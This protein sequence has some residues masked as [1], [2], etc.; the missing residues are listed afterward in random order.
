LFVELGGNV[1]MLAFFKGSENV[2]EKRT[3]ADDNEKVNYIQE[4]FT[5][6]LDVKHLSFLLGCGCSSH[7]V[8]DGA[9]T[10]EIG[11]PVMSILTSEFYNTLSVGDKDWLK[12]SQGLDIIADTF[13]NNLEL[14][15]ATLLSVDFYY[16]KTSNIGRN[17]TRLKALL[18]RARNF[19]LAKCLNEANAGTADQE[20]TKIYDDFYRKL[21][22]RNSNLP[23]PNIFTTNYDLYSEKALDR[24][25]INYVNGF[26]GGVNKYFNPTIFNYTLAERMD[27]TQNKWSQIDNIV[28]LYKLHGSVNWVED[29]NSSKLFQFREIQ[30][31][32]LKNLQVQEMI[33]IYPTPQKYNAT[34]GSPYSDLFRE[35]QKQL[36]QNN[37]ILVT[38]GYSFSD[39]HINNLIY[40]AFTIPSFRL[41]VIGD[42]ASS[43]SIAKLKELNDPR[44]WI[45]HGECSGLNLHYFKGFVDKILPDLSNEEIEDK[46]ENAIRTLLT[47]R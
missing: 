11:I 47:K 30:D 6:V 28:Y 19:L 36:M 18:K 25:G 15:L 1:S 32:S 26:T 34:L 29:K 41:I 13:E 43:A 21:L 23:R 17:A 44:I 42:P 16:E 3:F 46:I 7:K 39:E 33:M 22:F 8:P 5:K 35:F 2:L 40:Q 20:L 37:N 45:I 10:K 27:L 24:I 9:T 14:F 38:I 12:T 31:T 4:A